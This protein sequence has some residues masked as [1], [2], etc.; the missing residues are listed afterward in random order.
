[1]GEKQSQFEEVLLPHLDSAYNVAFWLV[2]ND[3][4]ARAIVEEA[5]VQARREFEKIGATNPR[6]WLLKI[7]LRIAHTWIQRQA[8]RSNVG[9]FPNDVSGKGKASSDPATER[10]SDPEQN[11][12]GKSKC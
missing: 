2:Q 7:V 5:Y 10:I 4:D 3:R 8:H 12:L 6:V 9:T 11:E 1:M